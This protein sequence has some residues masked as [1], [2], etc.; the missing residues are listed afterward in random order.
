MGT[1]PIWIGTSARIV[2]PPQPIYDKRKQHS[3]LMIMLYYVTSDPL[4][5]SNRGRHRKIEK[6]GCNE[7]LLVP[8]LC[9][10]PVLFLALG[11]SIP[12]SG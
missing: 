10:A 4:N 6:V 7:S 8:L 11:G 12:G 9:D 3:R 1:E 5:F 2:G